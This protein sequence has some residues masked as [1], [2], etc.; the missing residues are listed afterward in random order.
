MHK[1]VTILF[2]FF[3]FAFPLHSQIVNI[4]SARMQ[5]DTVGWKGRAGTAVSLTDNGGKVTFIDIYAHV[6]YKSLKDLWLI[7]TDY[8][9]LKAGG[10][11][12]IKSSFAHLRYN[13]KLNGWLRWEV[14]GQSQD[15]YVTRIDVRYL[16]GTGPRFKLFDTK[17]FRLYTACL[18]MYE[19]EKELTTPA[20][21]HNDIRNSSYISFTFLPDKNVEIISTTF[22]QPLLGKF[23]DYRILNQAVLRIKANKHF[24][25]SFNWNYLYDRFPAADVPNT[26][27]TFTMG[28]D[29]EF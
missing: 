27:Y 17:M 24:G 16:V 11:K 9:F 5:S 19:Y 26:T 2:I 6:Q 22:Y 14:F 10:Q 28:L 18:F 21:I 15:N 1:L 25:A 7:L 23:S 13:R 12:F 8:N 29:Y 20:V 4:E 3:F